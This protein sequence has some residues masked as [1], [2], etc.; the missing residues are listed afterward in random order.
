MAEKLTEQLN[1]SKNIKNRKDKFDKITGC[2]ESIKDSVF[3]G[4]VLGVSVFLTSD[5]LRRPHKPNP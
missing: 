2:G 4:S 3:G 1:K 5:I